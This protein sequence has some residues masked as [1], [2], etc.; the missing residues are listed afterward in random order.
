[1]L[2]SGLGWML[3][4]ILLWVGVNW[5]G[6]SPFTA[7]FIGDAVAVTYVFFTS[8]KNTFIHR[9]RFMMTKFSIYVIY[10]II[11]ITT[12]SWAIGWMVKQPILEIYL[13]FFLTPELLA[14]IILTP[15]SLILNFLIAYLL[16]EHI[17]R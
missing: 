16:I 5:V 8:S 3:A 4:M 1:M 10:Q 12:L 2:I 11:L 14:K 13:S 15:L 9:H 17:D 6:M 7:N